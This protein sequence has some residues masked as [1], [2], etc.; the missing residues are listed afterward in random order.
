MQTQHSTLSEQVLGFT[1]P[2]H[3]ARGRLVR[4]DGL[5]D[6]ILSAHDYP[7]PIAHLLAEALIVVTLAGSL[8][9]EPGSQLTMQAKGEGGA[10]NLLVCDYR[11]GELRGYVDFDAEA[12]ASS[13]AASDLETLFGKGYLA[14]TFDIVLPLEERTETRRHQGIVPL[15]GESISR[16]VESYFFQ[17]EQVPTLIRV[18]VSGEGRRYHAAGM[19][20]QHLPEGEEGRERLHV[21]LSHPA[22]EHVAIMA[23]SVR[24]GELLD[25]A[26]TLEA[27]LQRLF[28]EEREV[29][30]FPGER[31]VRGCRCSVEHYQAVLSGFSEADRQEMRN[32]A[33]EIVV[34]CAFCSTKFAIAA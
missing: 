4:L 28:H 29:R 5:L 8:I 18:A 31:M 15:E 20:V 12:V 34:D 11:G 30:I 16:A 9:K 6:A 26:L 13:G 21:K 23:G 33:G 3:D 2:E 22:W 25:P 7:A 10:V 17:S 19:L 24:H 14:L 27:I 1:V 32:D